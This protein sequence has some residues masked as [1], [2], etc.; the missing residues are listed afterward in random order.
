MEGLRRKM[1]KT[2][3]KTIP[4]LSQRGKKRGCAV[5][6]CCVKLKMG[7]SWGTMSEMKTDSTMTM[8]ANAEKRLPNSHDAGWK[9]KMMMTMT[10][11]QETCVEM[12]AQVI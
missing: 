4:E 5:R 6:A 12:S 3:W 8:T 1:T 2:T 10:W 11:F 7:Q 9:K